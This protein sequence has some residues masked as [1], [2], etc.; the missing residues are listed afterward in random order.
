MFHEIGSELFHVLTINDERIRQMRIRKTL[1]LLVIILFAVSFLPL[2]PEFAEAGPGGGTYYAN[3][4][5]GIR[6]AVTGT[7]N[8]GTPLRKFVDSLPG[9]GLPG[10]NPA[11]TCNANN[12]GQFIPIAS[13][14][15]NPLYPSDDYYEIGLYDYVQRMH[16]DLPKA[17]KLRG[18][19]D[20]APAADGLNHYLGPLIIATRDKAVRIKFVNNLGTGSSGNLFIPVD[21]TAMG[22]GMGPLDAG[23][24]P[25]D[26]MSESCAI[27]TQNRAAIHL[28]GGNTPWI[29]DGTPHQWITPAGDTTPFKKGASFQNVPDMVGGGKTIPTPTDGDGMGT[30]YYTNQQ[31]GRLMFYHDHAYGITRLNVYVG[32]AAGYLVVDPQEEAMITAG[33]LPNQGGA[34]VYRYGIPLIIQDKTFVPQ[35]VVIQ[36]SKWNTSIWGQPGDLWFPHIY[37]PNQD[38]A[39]GAGGVNPFGRWDYGPWFWPPVPSTLL[40]GTTNET[41]PSAYNTSMV[42]EAFMD[43]PIVNGAAYPYLQVKPQAYRFR[44]LN[45][46][47]DRTLNLQIYYVDPAHPTEVKMLPANPPTESSALPLCSTPTAMNDA[48]L[49]IGAIDSGTGRPLN[50]TGLPSGCWPTS[51]PTDGRDGGV[52]DPT[53]AGP[54]MIQIGTEGGFLPAPVV[55]P[56]TPVGYDYNRRSIVVLNVLNKGVFLQPAERADVIIDFSSVPVGS[57]LILYNDAPAPTPGFDPRYDYYTGNPDLT[58]GGGAPSTAVGYGPNTRTIM[59]F[60][61]IPGAATPFNLAALQNPATGLPN[62]FKLSQPAP[63]VP[64]TTYPAPYTAAIDTYSKI[65]DYSLTFDEITPIGGAQT[66]RGVNVTAGGS[67]YAAA[68][69]VSFSGGG[70]SGATA[71]ATAAGGVVTG[72]LLTDGGSG[73][74]SLPTITLTPVSGGSGAAAVARFEP[75]TIPMQPKAIQELWDP[76]G[77]M[78]ATLGVELPFTNNN[79]QTTIPLGYVDPVTE[80]V[81]EGQ[82]QLWK[83]THNGVDTHPVHFHLYNV[84]LINRVGWDGQIRRPDDNEIGWKET[85]RMNPLEDAI[86]A[87]APRTQTGLPFTVPTSSRST[88][89]TRP[90]TAMLSVIDPFGNI[91]GAAG[92][93][94]SI[95][96]TSTS[97]GWEYVWHCHILGHEENDFMR[98]FVMLV[99]TAAPDA[100]SAL[101]VTIPAPPAP[102]SD[103]NTALIDWTPYV[104]SGGSQNDPSGFRI[105]RCSGS[106]CSNFAPITTIFPKTQ[107]SNV[108][109]YPYA[110]VTT[111]TDTMLQPGTIYSYRVFA[112]NAKGDS[113]ASP[114]G[115]IT[116]ASWSP[117]TSVLITSSLPSPQTIGTPVTFSA[118]ASGAT[119]PVQY[120][121]W[122]TSGPTT[123]LVQDYNSSSTWTMSATKPAGVYTVTADAR[124]SMISQ[125][126]DASNS[127]AFTISSSVPSIVTDFS[128]TPVTGQVPLTVVFTDLSTSSPT[129]WLWDFG[130][131]STSAL[132]YPVH[133]YTTTGYFS[134]TLTATGTSGA[135]AET[136]NA[137]ISVIPCGNL[138]VKIS[139]TT[140]FYTTIPD[141]YN[142]ALSGDV[143]QTQAFGFAGPLSLSGD[144]A[145]TL[146][147]GFGCDFAA[148]PGYSTVTDSITIGG[149]GTVTIENIIVK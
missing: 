68:P 103:G 107:L 47:N 84:Q 85:V 51:W 143:V 45:A 110:Y 1:L 100:P 14:I 58:D 21:T 3:S 36:D 145:V 60:R 91:G 102:A 124:T 128:A 116:T 20:L 64:Q 19:R 94:V 123:T 148:N 75:K 15:S 33:I 26:P 144:N 70:G 101:N 92:N 42:P 34:A 46:A 93:P 38:P 55:I 66:L 61:I 118:V 65:Q 12:L 59:Q 73:Y 37:E 63:I 16:S 56:S 44:I 11:L 77:R 133:T 130:D 104:L 137:Y 54:A 108:S 30:Y 126:P 29:S 24:N 57:K 28:H 87:L 99:P 82:V 79:T 112:V 2:A 122:L 48:G 7:F 4:P 35:D 127:A 6:T 90:S 135:V 53:A 50:G 89:V 139:G 136:K 132:Q 95:A 88:D 41:G 114:A 25:C 9:L 86:V 115:T 147:G 76:Y 111:Y 74:T 138:P 67:G 131:S 119:T 106:G 32:E 142:V 17:T 121:F 83:I 72:I 141:A 8:T 80:T 27:Y 105:E 49:V 117:A 43:T 62:A 149:G 113:T 134:V 10:C 31:S 98:S 146:Q 81:P 13:K 78:N 120:R 23:G 96:N 39:Q 22:A 125:T 18:Y 129:E 140:S 71:T 52:P 97:F 109:A 5:A 69:S 40:P